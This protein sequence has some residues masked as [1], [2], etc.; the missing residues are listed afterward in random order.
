MS[1]GCQLNV[2]INNS[3]TIFRGLFAG[4]VPMESLLIS[5]LACFYEKTC[6]EMLLQYTITNMNISR[7]T[8]SDHGQFTQDS[9][10]MEI[11]S[12][13]FVHRWKTSISYNAFFAMCSPTICSY[14]YTKSASSAYIIS[15]VLGVYGGLT[16]F[17]RFLIL[18]AMKYLR[19]WNNGFFQ[20][21][22]G[23]FF[24]CK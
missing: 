19:R 20:Y 18:L 6:L 8:L 14:T 3:F 17:L 12:Q 11:L 1:T 5:T 10:I 21:N 7:L 16:V 13:L 2:S 24:Y 9:T 4:C 15:T 23:L 22:H